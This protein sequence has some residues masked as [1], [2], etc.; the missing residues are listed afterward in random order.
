MISEKS[1]TKPPRYGEFPDEQRSVEQRLAALEREVAW[2]RNQVAVARKAGPV[3]AEQEYVETS[4]AEAPVEPWPHWPEPQPGKA[5][6]TSEPKAPAR[7]VYTPT[8][9]APRPAQDNPELSRAFERLTGREIREGAASTPP[10]PPRRSTPAPAPTPGQAIDWE[11]FMGIKLFAWLGG[12]ALFLCAA[13]FVKYSIEHDLISPLMRVVLSFVVGAGVIAGGL[14]LRPRGYAVTVQALCAAGVTILYA[15]IFAA[16]SFY[17]FISQPVAFVL[18]SLVTAAAIL[19]A[20]RL[21]ARYVSVLGVI[22]GFLTPYLLSTGVDN[23]VG[24]FGYLLML[25]LGLLAVALKK[26]WDFL[27][28]LAVVGTLVLEIGWTLKFFSDEKAL[29]GVIV[30][31]LFGA[32]FLVAAYIAGRMEAR[33]P[34]LDAAAAVPALAAM[35]FAGF[36]VGAYHLGARPGLVLGFLTALLLGV[37]VLSLLEE[38]FESVHAAAAGLAFTVLL[39]WTTA[40]LTADL[41]P[42]GLAFYLVFAV[43]TAAFP[44][45]LPRVRP[46]AIRAPWLGFLPLAA[47][48]LFTMPVVQH[49]TGFVIW[50]FLL[51]ADIMVLAAAWITGTAAAALLAVAFTFLPMAVWVTGPRQ[52]VEIPQLLGVV[53]FFAVALFA[54]SL[55]WLRRQQAENA[56]SLR[57]SRS[58]LRQGEQF[59]TSFIDPPALAAML[60]FLLLVGVIGNLRPPSLSPVFGLALLLTA[61]LLALVRW[62]S[63]EAMGPGSLFATSLMTLAALLLQYDKQT[64]GPLL[65]WALVFVGVHLA[66][67][68]AFVSAFSSRVVPWGTAALAGPLL[69]WPIYRSA[70]E[71]YGKEA[72]G[73]LPAA[74]ALAYLGALVVLIKA[75]PGEEPARLAQKAWLGGATLFFVTLIFPLQFSKEWITI[76]WALEGAALVWLFR[77]VPHRG[78]ILWAT[79]LL[80]AAFVRLAL[81]PAV[82]TYHERAASPI[83]N[84]YLLAYGVTALAFFAAAHLLPRDVDVRFQ[85]IEL[86][87]ALRGLG[88]VLLFLLVNIEIADYFST[89]S[90]LTFRFT[91]SFAM[92]V[93]YSLAWGAF[94][95]G[96]LIVGIR[97]GHKAA[98]LSSLALFAATIGKVFLHDLWRLGQLYRVGS[99]FVLAVLL[100]LV[101]FLYQRFIAPERGGGRRVEPAAPGGDAEEGEE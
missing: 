78:L 68:L 87:G 46:D 7:P 31:L 38:G 65:A 88:T 14:L 39:Y 4:E 12:F 90:T 61:L 94:A 25:D 6:A 98:R 53:G 5:A 95:L 17:Q 18:M 59:L 75:L 42:W 3:V 11:S 37:S 58:D 23:P 19:L 84:W 33:T 26:R 86:R 1:P 48:L 97:T 99:I 41:L 13:F 8:P 54:A 47:L 24:L 21:D 44:L 9:A 34:L 67:P 20:L 83:L 36:M 93:A 63:A 85:E 80:A 29:T 52:S 91:G 43:L 2:L 35:A 69:F 66:F 55:L 79:G 101:S 100:I 27:V 56:K 28:P 49:L 57:T 64:P 22:G 10:A 70:V 89:G 60:P 71:I 45:L 81:N 15:D 73:L 76:G 72:I 51:L 96:L 62:R 40:A 74:L 32:L 77:R 30:W 50:P 92:D 82:V 16:R